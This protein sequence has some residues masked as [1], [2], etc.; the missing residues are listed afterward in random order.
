MNGFTDDSRKYSELLYDF[1]GV[2]YSWGHS[3]YLSSDC[4]GTIN[5]CLNLMYNTCM[6][7]CADD[8]YKKYFTIT[9]P[10]LVNDENS[11][12][13][14]FFIDSEKN[15]AVHVAGRVSRDWFLNM[16]SI[17]KDH[18]A[19]VRHI[20]ELKGMYPDFKTELRVLDKQK[21]ISDGRRLK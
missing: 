13:A 8:L 4:S 9:D 10:D 2:K 20:G 6:R 21:W 1:V 14:L 19:H 5:V 3:S 7:F 17:E 12:A 18:E 11:I 16:S 15:R